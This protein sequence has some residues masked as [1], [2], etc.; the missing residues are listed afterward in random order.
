MSRPASTAP[1]LTMD[2]LLAVMEPASEPG[3]AAAR[4]HLEGCAHCQSE[5]DRLHQRTARL[6]AL[7]ALKPERDRW[8]DVRRH[9]AARQLRRR[10]VWGSVG[11]VALAASVAVIVLLRPA[12]LE[13]EA[14]HDPQ[15]EIEAAMLQSQLL[16][17]ALAEYAPERRVTDGYTAGV[18][19]E[20]ED[21]ISAL[22]EELQIFEPTPSSAASNDLL[23][24][25]RERVGLMDALVDV[26]VTR[27]SHV[28]L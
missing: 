23:R 19:A 15:A 13:M 2:R 20:L 28:G 7:P 12:P 9:V 27:A 4:A 11:G 16:E 10:L 1:H 14:V 22:D 3:H 17:R 5:L 18:V 6:R 8:P 21:R 25:W 26:H 24:L